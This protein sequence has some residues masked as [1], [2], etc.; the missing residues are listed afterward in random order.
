MLIT[1]GP[2]FDR[3]RLA[4]IVRWNLGRSPL[5]AA[6]QASRTSGHGHSHP[7]SAE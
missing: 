7:A 5:D 4:A 3:A 6:R 1:Q 2:L